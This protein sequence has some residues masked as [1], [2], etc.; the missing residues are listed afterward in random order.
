M[1]PRKSIDC[2]I[3]VATEQSC[4]T[5]LT[6]RVVKV[7]LF[8]PQVASENSMRRGGALVVF[9]AEGRWFESTSHHV[10]TLGKSFIHSSMPV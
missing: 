2:V 7:L 1:L 4:S 3:E 8:K 6:P 9:G 5:F 10:G